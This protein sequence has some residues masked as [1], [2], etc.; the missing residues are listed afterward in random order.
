[1]NVYLQK[2]SRITHFIS[3][4]IPSFDWRFE[5]WIRSVNLRP[6][7]ILVLLR[8]YETWFHHTYYYFTNIILKILRC[9]GWRFVLFRWILKIKSETN[10]SMYVKY[11]SQILLFW[12]SSNFGSEIKNI[13]IE[14]EYKIFKSG[15]ILNLWYKQWLFAFYCT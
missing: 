13:L 15:S 8:P 1:M 11:Q 9:L 5:S 10:Y 7:C 14:F 6:L 3:E 12:R 2:I 4:Y